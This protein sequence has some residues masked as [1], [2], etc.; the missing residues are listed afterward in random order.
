[1]QYIYGTKN[2]KLIQK[3]VVILGNFDGV[4]LG[5][6]KL[7]KVAKDIAKERGL[8]TVAFSFYPH[9]TWV[10]G[11]SPKPLLMS[12]IEKKNK[13]EELGIDV[14]VEY[15]FNL[16]ISQIQP[17]DFITDVL[18]EKLNAQVVVIGSN[19]FFGKDKQGNAIYMKQMTKEY[20]FEV[21]ALQEVRKDNIV[22][23]STFIRDLILNGKIDI[24]MSLLGQPYT[25]RGTIVLGKQLGRTLGFPTINIIPDIVKVLPPNGVYIT[26][27]WLLNKEYYGLTNI[28][29]NPTVNGK[30]KMVETH[31]FDFT[32]DVY[33]K[34]VKIE[35]L[36][37][38]RPEIKFNSLRE[39]VEQIN[40]DKEFAK[41]SLEL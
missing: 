12:R 38:I 31:V 1:M 10:L 41:K 17:L 21:V 18:L 32:E 5:H 28:G 37:Y 30:T 22:V 36:D 6:Q 2:I 33:G 14:Y 40:K 26:K 16:E 3:S 20:G 34:E 24:A 27:L 4:H 29:Y 8:Q 11:N 15:P 7:F 25:V 39:L 23:S 9:P 19:Y 35:F 13:I